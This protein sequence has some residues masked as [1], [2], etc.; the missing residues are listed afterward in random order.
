MMA[1][2]FLSSV[3]FLISKHNI[4]IFKVDWQVDEEENIEQ[5]HFFGTS[6]PSNQLFS[7]SKCVFLLRPHFWHM[8]LGLGFCWRSS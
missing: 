2:T 1:F 8:C 5:T 7:G 4:I 6:L 3:D